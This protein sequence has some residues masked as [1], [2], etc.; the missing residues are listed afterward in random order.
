MRTTIYEPFS[1][2]RRLQDEMNRAFC[3]ALTNS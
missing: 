3:G 2:I 1:T